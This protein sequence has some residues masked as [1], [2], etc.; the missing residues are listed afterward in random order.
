[1]EPGQRS[2][3]SSVA[4][5][6]PQ[7]M[8]ATRAPAARRSTRP[9][10]EGNQVVASWCVYAVRKKRSMPWN[11]C[12]GI[13]AYARPPSPRKASASAPRLT[14]WPAI[15]SAAPTMYAGKSTMDSTAACSVGSSNVLA[16]WA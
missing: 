15:T 8:S 4:T 1:M 2:A 16:A 14:Y 6:R 3:I 5:P 7:P 10:T 9:G 11:M 12:A 13:A